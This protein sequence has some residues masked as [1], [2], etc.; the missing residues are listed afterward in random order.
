MRLPTEG[1]WVIFLVESGIVDEY[2]VKTL[3]VDISLD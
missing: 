2:R 1:G 3:W